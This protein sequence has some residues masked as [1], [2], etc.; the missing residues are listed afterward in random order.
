MASSSAVPAAVAPIT[1]GYDRGE[2]A[3]VV[4]TPAPSS[5]AVKEPEP[6]PDYKPVTLT[7]CLLN[8]IIR[9]SQGSAASSLRVE[10]AKLKL[11]L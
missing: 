8:E 4:P 7:Q 2:P 6:A 5:A 3:P 1:P 9:I 11:S 10:N